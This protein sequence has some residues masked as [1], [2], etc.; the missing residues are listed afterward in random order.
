MFDEVYL[1]GGA[2]PTLRKGLKSAAW[3]VSKMTT[4][5]YAQRSGVIFHQFSQAFSSY[6]E[7]GKTS[8]KGGG[9]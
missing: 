4:T 1:G 2:P 5:A 9:I 7:N 6:A 3:G 8:L